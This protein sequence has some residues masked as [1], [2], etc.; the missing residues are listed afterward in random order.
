MGDEGS[1]KSIRENLQFKN[2]SVLRSVET[3][4]GLEAMID[5]LWVHCVHCA[6]GIRPTAELPEEGILC[7]ATGGQTD[8]P[9]VL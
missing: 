5:P 2:P 1:A 3:D 8:T 9:R 7:A 4:I 6:T